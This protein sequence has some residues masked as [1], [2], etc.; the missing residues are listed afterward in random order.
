MI[1]PLNHIFGKSFLWSGEYPF[2]EYLLKSDY[3]LDESHEQLFDT[4]Q[5]LFWLTEYLLLAY[6]LGLILFLYNLICQ[7]KLYKLSSSI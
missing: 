6:R 3:F 5:I 4:K 7:I 1:V 2:L